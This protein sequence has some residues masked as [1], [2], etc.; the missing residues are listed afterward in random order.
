MGGP[1]STMQIVT[2]VSLGQAFHFSVSYPSTQNS[3]LIITCGLVASSRE[4]L[5]ATKHINSFIQFPASRESRLSRPLLCHLAGTCTAH[6]RTACFPPCPSSLTILVSP[7]CHTKY[8]RLRRG[9]G[10]NTD[11]PFTTV[12]EGQVQPQDA[13]RVCLDEDPRPGLKEATILLCPQHGK[14]SKLVGTSEEH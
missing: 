1:H 4:T 13:I 12:L 8:H 7:G 2:R 3:K 10:L 5:N 11:T 9:S 6:L 14:E